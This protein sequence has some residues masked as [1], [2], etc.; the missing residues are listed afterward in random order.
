MLSEILLN[1]SIKII[2]E[3]ILKVLSRLGTEREMDEKQIRNGRNSTMS[4]D[5]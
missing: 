3:D 5:A 4:A 1:I 2:I